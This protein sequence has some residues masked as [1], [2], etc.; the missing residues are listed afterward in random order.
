MR[1]TEVRY[2]KSSEKIDDEFSSVKPLAV[3]YRRF[4]VLERIL[5]VVIGVIFV[6][7]L[8]VG[9]LYA[10]EK[11]NTKAKSECDSKPR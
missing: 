9:I 10:S 3:G 6:V 7:V 8:I 4:T 1:S 2:H 5:M 11:K